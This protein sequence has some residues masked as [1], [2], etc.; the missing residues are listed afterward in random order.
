[1]YVGGGVRG[2]YAINC[3][4][5]AK[6]SW[7][8]TINNPYHLFAMT[9]LDNKLLIAGGEDVSEK[10]TNQVLT[11]D[12]G[13]LKNY[14]NMT[15]AR[16]AAAAAGHQ[17]MLIVTGGMDNKGKRLSSTVLFDSTNRQWYTC[18]DLP[19]PH[20]LLRLAIPYSGKFS[21]GKIF[22]NQAINWISEINFRN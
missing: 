5:P 22:G 9:T 16:S 4:D 19:Q 10:R 6:N 15:T 2:A 8:S 1:M 11:I 13:Q 14:T 3:Y 7:S 20:N 18:S 17:G 12:D 21:E